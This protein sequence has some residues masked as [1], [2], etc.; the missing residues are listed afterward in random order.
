[1]DFI[2]LS[3]TLDALAGRMSVPDAVGVAADYAGAWRYSEAAGTLHQVFHNSPE[4]RPQ[5]VEQHNS[6]G[7][8]CH[9]DAVANEGMAILEHMAGWHKREMKERA[10]HVFVCLT[11]GQDPAAEPMAIN[12]NGRMHDYRNQTFLRDTQIGFNRAELIKFLDR[13]EIAHS[14]EAHAD[15]AAK[16]EA[17][18]A[19]VKIAPETDTKKT[20]PQQRFQEREILLV[21][22]ELS[23]D[24][25]NLTKPEPGKPGV[26][27]EVRQKLALSVKVFDKAWER[28][29]ANLDIQD[30][31]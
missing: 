5:W 16:V 7:K 13:R 10:D 28:L 12:P 15:T 3:E 22:R 26:K 27:A 25:K 23:Y 11:A 14:L 4:L 24:P 18:P 1:M 8:P 20:L 17:V 30:A 31:E 2:T 9:N 6:T 21:I 19:D 29:R